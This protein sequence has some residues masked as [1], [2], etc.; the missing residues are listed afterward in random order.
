MDICVGCFL[1]RGRGV[2]DLSFGVWMPYGIGNARRIMHWNVNH[3]RIKTVQ[4]GSRGNQEG[5]ELLR[6]DRLRTKITNSP[7]VW[8]T[9]NNRD[10]EQCF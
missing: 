1:K 5:L 8:V 10:R 3:S 6:E 7:R 9:C 4:T 2:F